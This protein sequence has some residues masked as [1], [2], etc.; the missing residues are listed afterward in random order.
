MKSIV[1][2]LMTILKG[3]SRQEHSNQSPRKVP[4]DRSFKE[5]SYAHNA[6]KSSPVST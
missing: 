4:G 6:W 3:L 5:I 2:T 1:Q